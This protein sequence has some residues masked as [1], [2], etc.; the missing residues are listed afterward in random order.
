MDK[1]VRV[2][3]ATHVWDNYLRKFYRGSRHMLVHDPANSLREGDMIHVRRLT[4]QRTDQVRHVVHDILV[5]FGID[6]AD[7]AAVPTEHELRSQHAVGYAEKVARRDLRHKAAS[8]DQEAVRTVKEQGIGVK[9][10]V[11]GRGRSLKVKIVL[12]RD[13][14][15]AKK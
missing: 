8:G 3:M 1:T 5:P 2:S 10:V 6:I 13:F 14:V 11:S 15:K 12:E 7:R 4:S 9:E